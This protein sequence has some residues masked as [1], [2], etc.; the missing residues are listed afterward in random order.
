MPAAL[1]ALLVA[2][3][4]SAPPRTSDPGP[5]RAPS[6]SEKSPV[7]VPDG[8]RAGAYYKDDG[9]GSA[10]PAPEALAR[11]SDAA[12]RREPLHRYANKPYEVFGKQ[13]VPLAALGPY[14]QRGLG[15]WYGRRYHGAATSSG[16]R[17]DMYAMTAAHPVLPIPSY[18]RVTNL[19]NGKSVVVRINDRGPFHAGRIV[20]LSYTAAWKLGYIEAGSAL[21]EVESIVPDGPLVAQGQGAPRPAAAARA[22]SAAAAAPLP[23]ASDAKGVY[24]QLGAFSER[25]NAENFRARIYRQ[26]GWLSDAIQ[27]LAGG[28]LYRLHLGPYRS[29]DE[30]RSIAERIEG[31]LDLKPMLL[32]R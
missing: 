29:S 12:P 5:Y 3:C 22:E 6:A 31:E 14:S 19:A 13:Y 27:V 24:L 17:Y 23:Q 18:A 30:A 25:D 21:V 4:G 32:R 2:G 10:A 8:V 7:S 28:G 20:D 9:P 15:S 11:V 26:L 16:E 1:L